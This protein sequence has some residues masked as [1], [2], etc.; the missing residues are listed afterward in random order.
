MKSKSQDRL[1]SASSASSETVKAAG[2]TDF[3]ARSFVD[4]RVVRRLKLGA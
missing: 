4:Q 2:A 3:A 1:T